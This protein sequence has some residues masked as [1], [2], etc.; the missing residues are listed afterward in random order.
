MSINVNLKIQR[1]Q[2][3]HKRIRTQIFGTAQR[4]RLAVYKSNRYLHI[5]LIDDVRER[6]LVG[7]LSKDMEGRTKQ[8]QAHGTGK[9]LAREAL[10]KGI[11]SVVFDRAGFRYTGRVKSFAEGAREGGLEF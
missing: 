4:P 8:I 5:Q 1:R 9:I 11:K 6:T 7:L 10:K 2:R 3:R